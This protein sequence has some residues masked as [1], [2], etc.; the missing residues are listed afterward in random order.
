MVSM[1]RSNQTGP[2]RRLSRLLLPLLILLGSTSH[3]EEND[4]H[5]L[6]TTPSTTSEVSVI[7]G[8]RIMRLVY[9]R[10]GLELS[11]LDVPAARA[12]LMAEQGKSDGELARIPQVV[13]NEA[14]LLPL[15]IPLD[16]ARLVPLTRKGPGIQSSEGLENR[17]VGFLNGYRMIAAVLQ[18]SSRVVAAT[19]TFQLVKLLKHGRIDVALTLHWDAIAARQAYPDLVIGEPLLVADIHHWVHER[20]RSDIPCL[21]AALANMKLSGEYDRIIES[22]LG[23]VD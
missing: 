6:I 12:V 2:I 4:R 8:K 5:R 21:S 13:R 23:P 15:E 16:Q 9:E 1:V 10:C 18:E 20:H 17:T 7:L 19:D 14:P 3:G 11:Y 22:A